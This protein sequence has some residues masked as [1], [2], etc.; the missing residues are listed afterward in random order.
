M[1]GL[2]VVSADTW[3]KTADP[4][5]YTRL[6]AGRLAAASGVA[7]AALTLRLGAFSPAPMLTTLGIAFFGSGEDRR[8][9]YA[10]TALS[11]LAY[12][13]VA[14]LVSAG[15]IQDAGLVP[16]GDVG[17][18]GRVAIV[19]LVCVGF[20]GALW[21]AR[22]ARRTTLEAI[23]RSNAYFREAR[24]REAQLEEAN[25]DL[26]VLLKMAPGESAPYSGSRAGAY[27]LHERIGRGAMGEVYAAKHAQSGTMAAVKL[28]QPSMQD[29]SVLMERFHREGDAAAKLRA[30]NVVEIYE[31][32]SM[33]DGAPYLAM[34]LLRGH[35]LSWHLRR[36]GQLSLDEV[37][38]LVEHVAEGLEAARAAGV[39]H[40]DL[41]PQNLFLAQQTNAAPMWKILDFGVSRL[42]DS[43]GTL[44]KDVIVGTPGYMSPEQAAGTTATHQSDLFSFGAVVYRALTG[45]PPFQGEDTPQT[46]YQVVYKN[47]PC[48]SSLLRGLPPDLDLVL[49]VALAK[50]PPDRFASAREMA[51]AMHAAARSA[52]DPEIRLRARTL[53]A[54]LPWGTDARGGTDGGASSASRGRGPD[55]PQESGERESE[56]SLSDADSIDWLR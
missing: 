24:Q 2:G 30:P 5:G 34:E 40:R 53:L 32:G 7:A 16:A 49:A 55:D 12:A 20:A 10:F 51:R 52:L 33:S 36:R 25:R 17:A 15:Q 13:T 22:L 45:A 39:V 56:I 54:A 9:A 18:A 28:L 1:V 43:G 48:P 6:T 47:P 42:A 3:R 37:L 29:N 14:W 19:S 8:L 50:A 46:L 4:L 38:S 41:K 35:D 26:D 21:H 11:G 31:L 27:V 23:A 44:T